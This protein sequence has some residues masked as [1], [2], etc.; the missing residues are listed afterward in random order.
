LNETKQYSKKTN[1]NQLNKSVFF[2]FLTYLLSLSMNAQVNLVPNGSFEDTIQYSPF[3]IHVDLQNIVSWY[4]ANGNTPDYWTSLNNVNWPGHGSPSNAAGFQYAQEGIAYIGLVTYFEQQPA[5]EY[6]QVKLVEPLQPD[7]IYQWSFWISKSDSMG[8]AT[9][10]S[11]NIGIALHHSP[12]E[13]IDPEPP[14]G[15][16]GIPMSPIGWLETVNEDSVNWQK[17]M[18][19]Y[20][21]VGGE[22][23]LSIG[24]FFTDKETKFNN[25]YPNNPILGEGA[26]YYHVDNVRLEKCNCEL[27]YPNIITANLD[28]VNDLWYIQGFNASLDSVTIHN[29]WGQLVYQ[30][31]DICKWDGADHGEPCIDGVYYF[32]HKRENKNIKTGFIQLVR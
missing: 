23:Y 2:F 21:A 32:V 8:W 17:V 15:A 27:V 12:E 31:T 29:R 14:V 24:N 6:M 13:H 30:S 7:S 16:V 9:L 26:A 22:E 19:C 3:A 5:R 11:N 1:T 25:L 4:N 28:G 20:K 18:G 10:A